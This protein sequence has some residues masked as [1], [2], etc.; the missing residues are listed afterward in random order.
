MEE[1]SRMGT[2]DLQRQHPDKMGTRDVEHYLQ[3]KMV[4]TQEMLQTRSTAG[5]QGG[6]WER[7]S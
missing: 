2:S 7:W 5:I 3:R 6:N 4:H 1:L